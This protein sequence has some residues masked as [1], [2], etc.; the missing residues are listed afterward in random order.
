MRVA[1]V[2]EIKRGRTSEHL[3]D[4]PHEGSAPKRLYDVLF[5]HRGR[6]VDLRP[7]CR[8]IGLPSHGGYL[9]TRLAMLTDYYGCDIRK[10]LKRGHYILAGEWFGAHYSD[11][12][13][14]AIDEAIRGA[15]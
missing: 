8:E 10:G 2:N 4:Y 12:V 9:R 3:L 14:Q 11:Y 1:T 5:A 7:A 6:D 15:P 13:N